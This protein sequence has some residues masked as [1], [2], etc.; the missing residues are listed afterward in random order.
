MSQYVSNDNLPNAILDQRYGP[1]FIPSDVENRFSV[2]IIGMLEGLSKF[3]HIL[4]FR[5]LNQLLPSPQRALGVLMP[6][7]ELLNEV[8]AE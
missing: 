1:N 3:V 8:L 5:A 4:E 7:N 6:L 2:N